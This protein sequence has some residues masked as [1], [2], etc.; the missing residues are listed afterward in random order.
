VS[1]VSI[2]LDHDRRA[3][4]RREH[5]LAVLRLRRRLEPLSTGKRAARRSAMAMN[6]SELTREL[7]DLIAAL[8]RRVPRVERAGEAAIARDAATLRAKAADRLAE[9]GTTAAVAPESADGDPHRG[10]AAHAANSV[11]GESR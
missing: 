7:Q 11:P 10:M 4:A 2:V 5:V 9:L 3:E 8:D 6:A 1:N